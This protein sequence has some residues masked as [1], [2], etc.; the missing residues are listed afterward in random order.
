MMMRKKGRGTGLLAMP[1]ITWTLL[2][3]GITIG[4]IVV[5]SFLTRNPEVVPAEFREGI[6]KDAA[7]GL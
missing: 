1:M 4:Y 7:A 2:F 5:I 3:V 6:Y